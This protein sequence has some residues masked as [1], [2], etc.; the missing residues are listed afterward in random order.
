MSAKDRLGDSVSNPSTGQPAAMDFRLGDRF[1]GN[2]K[3]LSAAQVGA[4]VI[5]DGHRNPYSSSIAC[6]RVLTQ[7]VEAQGC[8]FVCQSPAAALS[9]E[10]RTAGRHGCS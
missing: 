5:S 3:L 7:G 1:T 4:H 9:L 2:T 10:P 8:A 6:E